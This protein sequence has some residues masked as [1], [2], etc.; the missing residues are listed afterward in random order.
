MTSI[1]S[2]SK[3]IRNME[4]LGKDIEQNVFSPPFN[5]V[6]ECIVLRYATFAL[7][8]SINSHPVK[9][10]SIE[11]V[12]SMSSLSDTSLKLMKSSASFKTST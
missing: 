11:A 3:Q 10:Y 5:L 6:W 8:L 12:F 4:S 2:K 9:P 1:R 7:I